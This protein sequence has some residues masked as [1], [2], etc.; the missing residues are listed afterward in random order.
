MPCRDTQQKKISSSQNT[1]PATKVDIIYYDNGKIFLVNLTNDHNI[2]TEAY[3][4]YNDEDELKYI[5][6]TSTL[7]NSLLQKDI[8]EFENYTDNG[9]DYILEKIK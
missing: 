7:N 4:L 5:V 3:Y 9:I 6:Q 1:F 8:V 2:K